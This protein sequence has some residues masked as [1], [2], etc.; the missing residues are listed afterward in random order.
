VIGNHRDVRVYAKL[1]DR[2]STG[3]S[4]NK[5]FAGRRPKDEL[6]GLSISVDVA[7]DGNVAAGSEW[8]CEIA[9][10]FASQDV[11]PPGRRTPK[12]NI[13]FTVAG[14]ITGHGLIGARTK[15]RR[16][17]LI[18]T[19]ASLIPPFADRRPKDTDIRLPVA[20]QIERSLPCCSGRI[21]RREVTRKDR[22]S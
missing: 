16:D 2:R 17:R 4:V 3:R 6:I 19:A 9:V 21:A 15:L 10:V 14:I 8:K 7:R 1:Q 11:P 5:P 18:V 20:V 13:G 22:I 12:R